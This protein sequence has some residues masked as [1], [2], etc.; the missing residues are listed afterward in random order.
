[1]N[2]M[3]LP[4]HPDDFDA[5]WNGERQIDYRRLNEEYNLETC[6]PGTVVVLCSTNSGDTRQ[7]NA[8]IQEVHQLAATNLP[9]DMQVRMRS[10]YGSLRH[11]M[12][13]LVLK[14][15]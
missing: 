1:M 14:V 6:Q 11:V 4:V 7:L 3:R 8:T 13:A 5:F 15:S 12:L 9:A 10:I 2:A